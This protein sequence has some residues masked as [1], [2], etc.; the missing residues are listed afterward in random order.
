[1]SAE[2]LFLFGTLRHAPLYAAVAG[3]PLDEMPAWL[4]GHAVT[5]AVGQDG[6]TLNF[7]LFTAR[8]GA[9][10]QGA[11]IRP[12]AGARARLDLYERVFGY[13]PVPMTVQTATGPVEAA[14]YL[15]DASRWSAGRDWSLT[16]WASGHGALTTEVASEVM[17]LLERFAPETVL[18][19]YAMLTAHVAS[20]RRAKVEAAP[21]HRRRTPQPGDVAVTARRL[22]Y[23]GFFGIEEQDL[24]FR[25][26]DGSLSQPVARAAFVAA[27]AVTLLPWDP[28]RDRV[29]VVEQFR[30]AP[31]V[32]GDG[33]PWT[34]EAIAGRVDANETPEQAAR[35]EA[36]E[37]AGLSVGALHCVGRYYPSPGAVTEYLYSYVAATDLPETAAGVHGLSTEAEDI[38]THIV[39]FDDAL[40]MIESGEIANAPLILSL[41]WL[42]LNRQRLRD[43]GQ[44][45]R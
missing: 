14:I 15:T 4:P 45:G 28:V 17:V 18:R 27:D 33:N 37:E 12:D 39:A 41:Q 42:A 40:A 23:A 2:P 7:P 11:L 20:R 25:H 3:Q 5:Q 1:M 9:R 21:A 38:R 31:F 13:E 44:S 29:M 10:A 35:R 16:D 26:H 8:P 34:L 22:P 6:S 30:F 43:G 32:R 24:R 36:V 19:R